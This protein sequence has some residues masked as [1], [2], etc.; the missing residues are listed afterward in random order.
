MIFDLG[1]SLL[2][3]QLPQLLQLRLINGRHVKRFQGGLVFK[4]HRLVYHSTPG[5][6]LMRKKKLLAQ[7]VRPNFQVKS[8]DLPPESIWPRTREQR[9]QEEDMEGREREMKKRAIQRRREG[10]RARHGRISA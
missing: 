7:V 6:G 10:G 1:L 5:W 8:P 4:A 2:T 3:R 9:E